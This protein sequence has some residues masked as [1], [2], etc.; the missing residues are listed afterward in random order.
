[1]LSRE[2]RRSPQR[3]RQSRRPPGDGADGADETGIRRRGRRDGDSQTASLA[4]T[5]Q[6]ESSGTALLV[7]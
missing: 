2:G 5:G 7:T 3:S 4:V 6:D 1:M